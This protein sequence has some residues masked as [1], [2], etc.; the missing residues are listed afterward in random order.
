MDGVQLKNK[1]FC[2]PE[3]IFH[4]LRT[5]A[6]VS[7]KLFVTISLAILLKHIPQSFHSASSSLNELVFLYV[8][9]YLFGSNLVQ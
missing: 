2:F 4:H 3:I 5:N 8:P 7:L 6:F 1:C 9:M